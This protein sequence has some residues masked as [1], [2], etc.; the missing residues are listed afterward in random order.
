MNSL[1][2][3]EAIGEIDGKY[4]KEAKPVHNRKKKIIA[5]I[6]SAAACLILFF[7]IPNIP[8]FFGMGAQEGDIFR[9]GYLIEDITFSELSDHFNGKLLAENII[10]DNYFEFYSKTKEFSENQNDWYSLLYSEY[11][12]D[13]KIIM[14][15]M[16]GED[17]ENWKIDMVFTEEATKTVEINGFSVEIAEFELSLNYQHTHY[18]LFEYDG[19]TYDLRI[20]SNSPDT[21]YNIL[22]LLLK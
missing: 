10:G 3:F 4:I 20:S 16:F 21:V 8:N 5:F 2:L 22:E 6:A 17:K 15:C 19:V 14:H 12:Y 9:N 18:A 11:N 1:L 13:S 7:F